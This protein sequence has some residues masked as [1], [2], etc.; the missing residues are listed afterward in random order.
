M[1]DDSLKAQ[2]K[3][4]FQ[5]ITQ[6]IEIVYD[7]GDHESKPELLQYLKDVSDQSPNISLRENTVNTKNP[8]HFTI[9]SEG[10]ETGIHFD[11]IPGGH[12]FSSFI[13]ALLQSGGSPV[14]LDEAIQAMV[15]GIQEPLEFETV[16]SLDCHNCPDVVQ[17]LN[18]LS[19]LNPNFKHTMIDGALF[20]ELVEKR[21]VQG[22][23][24]VFLNGEGFATGKVDASTII[25]RILEKS[26][27]SGETIAVKSEG[28]AVLYDVVV[29]G[30]G[31]AGVASAVYSARK[32][33]NVLVIADKLG[34]QVKDTM[35][36]ENLISVLKTTGPA[37]T[38]VL[39]EQLKEN[40]IKFKEYLRVK[41]IRDLGE[42]QPKE[43][44]LNSGEVIRTKTVIIA[45]GAKW[46]ELNVPGEKENLGS[47][48]AYCP[49]CDGPF[50]KGKDVAVVGGGNSGVEAALDLSGIV[51]SV[52]LLEFTDTLKAD[53][54]L[55]DRLN[56]TPNIKVYTSAQTTEVLS[57]DG[58]V[59]GLVYKDRTDDSIKKIDLDGIFVQIG[60]IPN[61][62]FLKGFLEMN[63]FGEIV[64]DEKCRTSVSGI[65]ACGDVT[66]TPYK[67]IIISMG[68]GAKASLAAFEYLLKMPEVSESEEK[69]EKDLVGTR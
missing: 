51:S 1:I 61:S 27:S 34:G 59:T 21:K 64:I 31:P 50:F 22:V 11:G 44:V 40:G 14:R 48:V 54:V 23:P 7:S 19:L 25:Q 15:K 2:L 28:D 38:G 32:G 24:T 16:V 55:L 4:Y 3:E 49:H 58:K 17:T 8:L 5:K 42:Y 13:L 39:A 65:F 69:K 36:I 60:L 62:E 41:E 68:E 29:V 6:K 9:I 46:R 47:G 37:L 66:T 12:E 57:R 33:L 18:S 43:L 45:T 30:G 20:P 67:Q 56:R 35:G 26:Q 52:Q 63:R 10:K 53:Q